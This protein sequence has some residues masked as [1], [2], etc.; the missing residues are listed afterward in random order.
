VL[1]LIGVDHGPDRL[2]DA[3]GDVEGQ[4]VDH[5]AFGV[6]GHQARLA[7]DPGR[8]TA[9]VQLCRPARDAEHE[10]GHPQGPEE[11]LSCRPG[12]TAAIS[13]H[14]HIGG[15]QVEQAGQVAARDRGEEP[16]RH[17]LALLPRGVEAGFLAAGAA[18]GNVLPGPGKDLAAVRPGLA[19]DPRDLGVFVAEYLMEQENR[20]FGRGQALQ[21]DEEGHRQGIRHFRALGWV[22]FGARDEGFG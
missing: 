13:D 17:L 10:A 22:R 18:L 5:Q 15:E 16:A 6:V 12:L 11:R 4:H 19:G 7:V 20:A 14:D 1:E 2:N 21:Q 3:V 8:L 9:G